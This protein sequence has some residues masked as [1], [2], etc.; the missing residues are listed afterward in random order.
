M[1]K[2]L[3]KGLELREGLEDWAEIKSSRA[4]A[5]ELDPEARAK[6][7][8]KA[9]ARAIGL[10]YWPALL[11]ELGAGVD[12][13]AF[14]HAERVL[15]PLTGGQW[16]D[17][18]LANGGGSHHRGGWDS[19]GVWGVAPWTVVRAWRAAGCRPSRKF[20]TTVRWCWHLGRDQGLLVR[21][22]RASS[23]ADQ[24]AAVGRLLAWS[25]RQGRTVTAVTLCLD[26]RAAVAL[27]RLPWYCRWAAIHGVDP[28]SEGPLRIRHLNWEAV[29]VAQR[30]PRAAAAAGLLPAG[31][32]LASAWFRFAPTPWIARRALR[33]R[34]PDPEAQGVSR[35]AFAAWMRQ[36]ALEGTDE[37]N[38]LRP[39]LAL[40]RLFGRDIEAARR[41]VG[42]R[43]VHDAGQ[44]NLPEERFSSRWGGWLVGHPAGWTWVHLLAVVERE[45]GRLPGSTAELRAVADRV[46]LRAPSG[47]L[48]GLGVP[49]DL[50]GDYLKL[51]ASP[52][53]SYEMVPHVEV[54]DGEYTLRR[55]AADD[56]TGVVAGLLT[57]CCQHLH[58]AAAA[59]ARAV[60]T[61]PDAAVWV[62]RK[63]AR[64]VAQAFVWVSTE[65][66]LV[67]DSVEAL[68]GQDAGKL[69]SL[70]E[71]AARRALGVLGVRRVLI[72]DTHYGCSP[73]VAPGGPRVATPTPALGDFGYSDARGG[74][75]VV[76]EGQDMDVLPMPTGVDA[77]GS[78][79]SPAINALLEDSGVFCEWCEAEVHPLAETCPCCGRDISEWVE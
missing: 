72:G 34:L 8:A 43:S 20:S 44:L 2:R 16:G 33:E 65:G 45:L 19:Y 47:W 14:R 5:R 48:L 12:P 27:G 32:A 31:V 23:T 1:K 6:A 30:G 21:R 11:P 38:A 18:P 67:L 9:R 26:Y 60:W 64:V 51:F 75:R 15:T 63:A 29:K 55:L 76:A 36:A 3:S 41:F 25:L 78:C 59:C 39:A 70:F 10:A 71:R 13:R 28:P 22:I 66:D 61:R 40:A 49:P 35:S 53:K 37:A 46:A 68:G 7:R 52:G 77:G 74:C 42:A 17:P 54:E 69:A 73:R 56:P 58:G 57:D 50:V 24:V 79:R 4:R 62:V